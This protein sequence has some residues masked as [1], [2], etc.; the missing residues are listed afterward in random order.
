MCG[1]AAEVVLVSEFTKLSDSDFVHTDRKPAVDD[2]LVFEFS[3]GVTIGSLFVSISFNEGRSEDDFSG[4]FKDGHG[5]GRCIGIVGEGFGE[6]PES[7][8]YRFPGG[9]RLQG[10][11]R[12]I[13]ELQLFEGPLARTVDSGIR[14]SGISFEELAAKAGALV[15]IESRG[16]CQLTKTND[17]FFADIR[18]LLCVESVKQRFGREFDVFESVEDMHSETRV[19]AIFE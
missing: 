19:G 12:L 6:V 9:K 16:G 17:D 14:V 2:S 1:Y 15:V 5:D 8:A 10:L 13:G 11:F 18:Q 7:V 3:G 4:R